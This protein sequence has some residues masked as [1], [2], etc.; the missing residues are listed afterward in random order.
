MSYASTSALAMLFASTKFVAKYTNADLQK[1]TWL[2]LNLFVKGQQHA[3]NQATFLALELQ[4]WL[5]KA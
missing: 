2:T 5:F 4:E 1:A 3:Q